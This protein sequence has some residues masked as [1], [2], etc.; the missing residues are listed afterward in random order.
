MESRYEGD[1]WFAISGE[2]TP[3]T[4]AIRK[5]ACWALTSGS[6]GE[7]IGD[8]DWRFP[9]GWAGRLTT[10]P[11]K[12]SVKTIRDWFAS[13]DWTSLV[14]DDLANLVTAGR[15]T[16]M[17]ATGNTWDSD[18]VTACYNAAGT[19]AVIY[20]PSNSGNT[21]RTITIDPNKMAAGFT[22]TWVNPIDA[23]QQ[24]VATRSGNNYTDPGTHANGTR[25]WLLWLHA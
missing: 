25:D 16:H 9:T 17:A 2:P 11:G 24:S 6:P 19:L 18:W 8:N 1:T 23:T 4:E 5:Q 21:A 15:G 13:L 14:P 20:I 12:N 7:F 10:W 3:N 22:G